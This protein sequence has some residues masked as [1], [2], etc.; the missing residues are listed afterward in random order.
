[1]GIIVNIIAGLI[2]HRVSN[3][4]LMGIGAT[5]YTI[6]F[7]LLAMNRQQDSYWKF[8]FPAF[9]FGVIGADLE[10]NVANM[11]VMSSLPKAQQSIAG[12]IFQT[13]TK[14]CMTLG[15]GIAT[16]LY[17]T[18]EKDP[19]L[20]SYWDPATQPFTAT[21]WL[22][23]ASA[24]TSV[25]LV[26]FLTIGTQGGKEKKLES[27]SDSSDGAQTPHERTGEKLQAE[28]T[29]MQALPAPASEDL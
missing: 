9:L 29:V 21:F 23:A 28:A 27:V 17:T 15:L 10:F 22:A 19:S 6:S 1:M 5:A 7:T 4:L 25:C 24:G 2:L 26:P 20:E 14:L 3:K 13:V 18:M 8:C 16:A 12:G 11:Y